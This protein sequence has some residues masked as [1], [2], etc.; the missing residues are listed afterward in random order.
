MR[1][2]E[3]L[4]LGDADLEMD[5]VVAGD[6]F[7]DGMFDLE[8][9]VH[10]EEVEALPC[11]VDEEL[12][13]AGVGVS[14]GEREAN[15]GFAHASAEVGIDDRG[16]GFLDDFLMAALDG[17]FALAEGDA[18]AMLVGEDLDFD[19]AGAL[20][21]LLEIDLAGAEGALGFTAGG[22]KGGGQVFGAR[23]RRASL[24]RRRQQRP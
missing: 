8:T 1:E 3:G 9:G 22:D 17:A 18:V 13:G 11:V 24:Y 23:R 2:G 20:D 21:E 7:G 6:E 19:V 16:R 5:E 14:G 12:D 15:G 4:A 10:L